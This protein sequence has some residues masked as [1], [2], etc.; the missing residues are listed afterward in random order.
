MAEGEAE[1][2]AYIDHQA[3]PITGFQNST[4]RI[5]KTLRYLNL[6]SSLNRQYCEHDIC[7]SA[8][9]LPKLRPLL[10]L[11]SGGNLKVCEKF[12]LVAVNKAG[13]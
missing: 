7:L 2:A 1:T 6:E 9:L 12:A 8:M 4:N 3:L 11:H 10:Q 5:L 13:R